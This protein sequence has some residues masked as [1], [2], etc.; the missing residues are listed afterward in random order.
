MARLRVNQ[1]EAVALLLNDMADSLAQSDPAAAA[2]VAADT[3]KIVADGGQPPEG[4][5]YAYRIACAHQ[6]CCRPPPKDCVG[7]ALSQAIVACC[8]SYY[9]EPHVR[10]LAGVLVAVRRD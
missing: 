2:I 10:D 3:A 9:D 5:D 1:D 7:C 6:E 8:I 4:S